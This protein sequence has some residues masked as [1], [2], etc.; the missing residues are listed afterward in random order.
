[1]AGIGPRGCNRFYSGT[2][3]ILTVRFQYTPIYLRRTLIRTT[4]GLV[5]C[6]HYYDTHIFH[7][8]YS[9]SLVFCN[10]YSDSLVRIQCEYYF[11]IDSSQNSPYQ[12][13]PLKPHMYHYIEACF[14]NITGLNKTHSSSTI[15]FI[16]ICNPSLHQISYIK[17]R[18]FLIQLS[19]ETGD[20]VIKSEGLSSVPTLA[21][22]HSYFALPSRTKCYAMELLFFAIFYSGRLEF[23]ANDW[24]SQLTKVGS[25][26][27]IP[28]IRSLYCRP[29]IYS[30][31]CVRATKSD[32][33]LLVS[34]LVF[35]L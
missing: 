2:Q 11:H 28:I 33:K 27:G 13:T 4:Y 24:L 17:I 6:K 23:V 25:S 29:L 3:C 31:H 26:T 8:S 12:N 1:M 30:Q 32:P 14:I 7:K 9:E 34:T 19:S 5:I 15:R 16:F 35:Y 20:S 21:R 22:I 10:S 18:T